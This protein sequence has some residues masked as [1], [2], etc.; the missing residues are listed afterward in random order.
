MNFVPLDVAGRVRVKKRKTQT[1]T[2]KHI[3]TISINIRTG[4]I[5]D[6]DESSLPQVIG[7]HGDSRDE[8]EEE[9]SI[10]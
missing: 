9:I 6:D 2:N 7:Q 1:I 5:N 3:S 10:Q 4:Q 8:L